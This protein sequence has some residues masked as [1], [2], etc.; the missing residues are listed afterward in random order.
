MT[1]FLFLCGKGRPWRIVLGCY[2]QKSFSKICWQYNPLLRRHG[3]TR[4]TALHPWLLARLERKVFFKRESIGTPFHLR[5]Q[6]ENPDA[7]LERKTCTLLV[8]RPPIRTQS[9]AVG[10]KTYNLISYSQFNPRI[11]NCAYSD[12]RAVI[13]V[14]GL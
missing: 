13:Q 12:R 11:C 3:V 2:W 8:Q 14:D 9:Q 7:T 1:T 10:L 6:Q 5:T 4:H